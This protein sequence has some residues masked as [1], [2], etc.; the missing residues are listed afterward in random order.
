MDIEGLSAYSSLIV[1]YSVIM[2]FGR[3]TV[4]LKLI[5]LIAEGGKD[6]YVSKS[7]KLFHYCVIHQGDE[8]NTS[9]ATAM[10]DFCGILL[11]NRKLHSVQTSRTE[12]LL[13]LT[14]NIPDLCIV[15]TEKSV[16][17]KRLFEKK[18]SFA[19]DI[20]ILSSD[21]AD[22]YKGSAD[23]YE[24]M[25]V[26]AIS[27]LASLNKYL[28]A[29]VY[30]NV[31]DVVVTGDSK[32]ITLVKRISAGAEGMVFTTDN[33]KIVAKIYHKGVITP[34]R[35]NKLTKMVAMGIRTLG[36][37]WPQD[38][39]FYRGIPVGYTMMTGKGKTLGN[40]FDGPD[41]IKEN[42]PKWKRVDVVGVLIDLLE[43]YLYLHM[44]DII[45]G[46]IQ[47]K[48]AL[49][50]SPS[51][52]YLIDMDSV[53]VGNLPCP[54]GTEEFTDPRLWGRNFSEFL[55]VPMDEDYSVAMLVF[56]ILF[57]GL[58]PYATR[59]GKET[60]REEILEKNFPYTLDNSSTEHIPRG[61]Y[62]HIWEYLPANIR[63]MLY[64]VFALGKSYEAIE[65]Y[66]AVT[67]YRDALNNRKFED[68]EAYKVFPKM[69]YDAPSVSEE[70]TSPAGRTAF[71]SRFEEVA[72]GDALGK[73]NVFSGSL[74][75]AAKA[76]RM[77]NG[78]APLQPSEPS[79][80]K[81][82]SGVFVP[83]AN[84]NIPQSSS[85]E[86]KGNEEDKPVFKRFKGI[87]GQ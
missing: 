67:E 63:Q 74:S 83:K 76:S 21:N 56:S 20:C 65:W 19:H 84:G 70:A 9:A 18:P 64:D 75:G 61:G 38:L 10:R 62:D 71:M 5:D 26:E 66:D 42:F 82:P 86:N 46:D 23:L 22:Y 80:N 73:P 2:E 34:L 14:A 1:D 87:F 39:L 60:L 53:Q 69:D 6:V 47:L 85:E 45:A 81:V 29:P 55:R 51:A 31:G 11:Q 50:Y 33:P 43:K 7:F 30:C 28:E 77:N 68:E 17:V 15:A 54:V 16:F 32:Q 40:V 78:F 35:W 59:N 37:C 72:A 41:A 52:I 24:N 12:D 4:F 3:S 13:Q 57:C 49:L 36:I 48:N 25:P 8:R 44:H 58:H 79:P 27:P